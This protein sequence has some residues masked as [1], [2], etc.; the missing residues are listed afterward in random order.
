MAAHALN[1]TGETARYTVKKKRP[2][3]STRYRHSPIDR[4][5]WRQTSIAVEVD[6][7]LELLPPTLFRWHGPRTAEI[8]PAVLRSAPRQDVVRASPRILDV[9]S[10]G[11]SKRQWHRAYA[12]G[13]IAW[14]AIRRGDRVLDAG[15][16]TGFAAI[17]AALAVGW[18]GHVV[19]VDL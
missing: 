9:H 11:Y 7:L 3:G 18:D 2:T 15:V 8:G 17:A 1:L 14:S 16:G 4:C 5:E 13:L 6:A 19:G 10:A 12:A